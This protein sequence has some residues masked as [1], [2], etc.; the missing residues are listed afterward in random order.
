MPPVLI[1]LPYLSRLFSQRVHEPVIRCAFFPGGIPEQVNQNLGASG[2]S[3]NSCLCQSNDHGH[4]IVDI[5]RLDPVTGNFIP[6]TSVRHRQRQVQ[7]SR[8][9]QA[10]FATAGS[11]GRNSTSSAT[12]SRFI[13]ASLIE[14]NK[15]LRSICHP[16]PP[17]KKEETRIVSESPL[18]FR[19]YQYST[20]K[21]KSL[22]VFFRFS[23]FSASV[24]AECKVME[25]GILSCINL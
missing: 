25:S 10:P 13:L 12:F 9:F 21:L 24:Q 14:R 2:I 16:S 1:L 15:V 22:P 3:L 19:F 20:F 4:L 6:H 17:L 11:T 7:I 5:L 8:L 23:N 18:Q